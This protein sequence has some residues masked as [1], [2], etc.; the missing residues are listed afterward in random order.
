M[1]GRNSDLPPGLFISSHVV[2]TADIF[3]TLQSFFFWGGEYLTPEQISQGNSDLAMVYRS[4]AQR[5]GIKH[6]VCLF[7]VTAYH[8]PTFIGCPVSK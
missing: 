2:V 5:R 4:L 1:R 6:P 7:K 3:S 8:L